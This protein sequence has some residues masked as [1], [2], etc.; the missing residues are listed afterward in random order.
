MNFLDK[1]AL[2]LAMLDIGEVSVFDVHVSKWFV[3]LGV[4]IDLLLMSLIYKKLGFA[5]NLP[6]DWLPFSEYAVTIFL[7]FIFFFLINYFTHSADSIKEASISGL[8]R[9]LFT[10]IG[11]LI[12]PLSGI[13]LI[14]VIGLL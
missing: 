3:S 8:E 4:S 1:S 11:I 10:V 2:A 7:I 12:I 14:V 13:I 9:F 6:V 5:A